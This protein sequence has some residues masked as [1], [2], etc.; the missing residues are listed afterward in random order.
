MKKYKRI[1]FQSS[2][3]VIIACALFVVMS[4]C[5]NDITPSLY[6]PDYVGKP[7]PVVDSISPS[8][9][10]LAATI[11][12]TIYGKNFS[13]TPDENYVFFSG[14]AGTVITA[15]A[16]QLVV[17]TPA[18]SGN[19]SVKVGVTGADLYSAEK[20]YRLDLAVEPFGNFT[21]PTNGAAGLTPDSA[22]NIYFN[23]LASNIDNGV[24]IITPGGVKTQYGNKLSGNVAW[25]SLKLG[26]DNFLYG[27]RNA[28]AVYRFGAGGGT[29]AP[30]VSIPA[31]NL[32]SD[33]DFDQNGNLWAGGKAIGLYC[34]KPDK[35]FK[36]STF[37]A[38][39]RA[40]R[41]FNGHLYFS[42]LK[43]SIEQVFRAPI[44]GDTLGT[45]TPYFNIDNAFGI[46]YSGLSMTISSDGYLYIA[47]KAPEGII[48][49]APDGSYST[50][51][52]GYAANFGTSCTSLA[53]GEGDKLLAA[54]FEGNLNIL[55]TNKTG[56]PYYG[57]H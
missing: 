2:G 4:G 12:I 38:T 13:A 7:Q 21:P 42:A 33:M 20:T 11:P 6:D 16:T 55:R 43:D 40:V 10:A 34:I 54:T 29:A 49:V 39:V 50:P 56:A 24:Y 46:G 3:L 30:W 37:S 41:V 27:A 17:D 53:W 47:T 31:P 26:Q 45:I 23:L 8:G 51:F 15:T 5:E 57:V 28:R 1:A 19:M 9:G 36:V 14:K 44:N 48:I 18:D 32:L 22:G 52:K 25:T 35:S